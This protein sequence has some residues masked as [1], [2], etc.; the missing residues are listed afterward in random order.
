M[1]NPPGPRDRCTRCGTV[2][3]R[4]MHRLEICP[5]AQSRRHLPFEEWFG[6]VCELVEIRLSATARMILETE[7]RELAR[8]LW[9][10]LWTVRDA[11]GWLS[12]ARDL[13]QRNPGSIDP[14]R[15]R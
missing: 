4:D 8:E 14:R 15:Q 6:C 2:L 5:M 9:R 12:W 1:Y 13:C 3:V 7:H 10:D 11:A